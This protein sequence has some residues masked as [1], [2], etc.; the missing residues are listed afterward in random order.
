MSDLVMTLSEIEHAFSYR[1]RDGTLH[2]QLS[3]DTI[4][5][6]CI[7]G[8]LNFASKI[9]GRWYVNVTKQW[10]ELGLVREKS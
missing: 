1:D 10:P 5:R 3:K 2:K 6:D 8:K 4:R 9:G 7:A